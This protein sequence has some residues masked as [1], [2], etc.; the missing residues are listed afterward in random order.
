MTYSSVYI[1]PYGANAPEES[2]NPYI[3]DMMEGMQNHCLVLNYGKKNRDGVLDMIKNINRID[4]IIL[5]W[6]ESLPDR[7]WG[8]AQTLLL[9]FIICWLKW[10]NRKIIW[11]LHNKR[12]H[13]RTNKKFKTLL[14]GFIMRHATTI[15]THSSEGVDYL[16]RF[17]KGYEEKAH[18]I[19]HPVKR[20]NNPKSK[21]EPM[22][23]NGQDIYDIIIWGTVNPYK[24][25]DRFLENLND[26]GVINKYKILI[27]GKFTSGD[28]YRKVRNMCGVRTQIKNK[29]IPYDELKTLI[30]QSKIILFPYKPET[31][32]SSG[33]LADSITYDSVIIGPNVGAFHDLA[34][35]GVIECFNDHKE[36]IGLIDKHMKR[37]KDS[38]SWDNRLDY[39]RENTWQQFTARLCELVHQE[40]HK[41]A[42]P[43]A[44]KGY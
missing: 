16:K 23:L 29:Y 13:A 21:H 25:I 14:F 20:I 38:I 40:A 11:V 32:L 15:I 22:R 18:F 39:I 43:S 28:Y 30:R 35:A 1:Y 2:I 19:P 36:L 37:D 41:N 12:P 31:I 7:K 44:Q 34:R 10:K 3:Q 42:R 9:F 27:A 26:S 5:N 4:A 6:I 8:R 24:G 17:G 33:A